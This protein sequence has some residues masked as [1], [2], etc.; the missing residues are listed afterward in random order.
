M[1]NS[2]NSRKV[3]KPSST[4]WIYEIYQVPNPLTGEMLICDAS[5]E[6]DFALSNIFNP[7]V[8]YINTRPKSCFIDSTGE[9]YTRDA[10]IVKGDKTTHYE[11]KPS[12]ALEKEKNKLKFS[13]IIKEFK[14]AGATLKTITEKDIHDGDLILNYKTL[15]PYLSTAKPSSS[16]LNI[17]LEL[18]ECHP[19]M[20]LG[21]LI[22]AV[23]T[24]DFSIRDIWYC[25]AHRYLLTDLTIYISKTSVIWSK[26]DEV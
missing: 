3:R 2:I 5:L 7:K 12:S 14:D 17:I 23:G 26:N 16:V 10:I 21:E 20:M 24:N 8:K 22:K 13:A 4:S 11:I 15:F 18:V 1:N 19:K 6:R 25:L 9:R